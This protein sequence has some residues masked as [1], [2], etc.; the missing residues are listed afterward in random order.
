MFRSVKI[1]LVCTALLHPNMSAAEQWLALTIAPDGAWGAAASGNVNTAMTTA[2][3]QCK[4]RSSRPRDVLTGCGALLRT[5][6]NGWG[7]AEI[8]GRHWTVSVEPT[9]AEA[10]FHLRTWKLS[11]KYEYGVILPQCHRVITVGPDGNEYDFIQ[12]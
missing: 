4:D 5:A 10:E 12:Y 3:A 8:C 2:I 6:R 1:M 7:I 9:L 11:M